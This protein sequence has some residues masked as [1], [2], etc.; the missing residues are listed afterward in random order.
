MIDKKCEKSA[1]VEADRG[2]I[3]GTLIHTANGLIPIE[4]IQ[5]GDLLLSSADT[6][7]VP[8]LSRVIGNVRLD[9]QQ[10]WVVTY[11]LGDETTPRYMVCAG[12]QPFWTEQEGW[13]RADLLCDGAPLITTVETA[14]AVWANLLF[15]TSLDGVAWTHYDDGTFRGPAVDMRNGRLQ[16]TEDS[17]APASVGGYLAASLYRIELAERHNYFVGEP[18]LLVQGD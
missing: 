7:A 17:H 6:S 13:T 5:V 9:A 4:A 10:A 3:T 2:F 15:E 16:F 18:G 1:Q 14:Y 8:A 11:F 12:G